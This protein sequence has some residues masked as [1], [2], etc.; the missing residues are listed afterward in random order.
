MKGA[1]RA[2]RV[3]SREITSSRLTPVSVRGQ[4]LDRDDLREP[5][6]EERERPLDDLRD[7][8]RDDEREPDLAAPPLDERERERDPR[9][10]TLPPSRRASDRPIAMACFRLLTFLPDPPDR[11]V[12][13]LRSCMAFSTLSDAFF[14]Y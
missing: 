3:P 7:E 13:C 5:L 10:G 4:R 11:S 8:E 14:P 6:D 1:N 2:Y 9:L 12:P